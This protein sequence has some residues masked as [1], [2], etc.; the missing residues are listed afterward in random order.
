MRHE[1]GIGD[2]HARRI[3]MGPEHADGLAGL[4]QQRLVV[5]Q[6]LQRRDDAVEAF[7]VARGAADAA[8]DHELLG[9]LGHFG[10]EVVHQHAH[11]RFGEP[12]L[13]AEIG[14]RAGARM[15]RV[16]SRRVM[17]CSRRSRQACED[18]ACS[19][20][21]MRRGALFIVG[22]RPVVAARRRAGSSM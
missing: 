4:D 16:L 20:A 1:V 12:A 8:I 19:A 14:C 17:A 15:W 18:V 3:G 2:Q 11:R 9:P 6:P 21:R 22:G 5:L 10:V 7:P 13:A